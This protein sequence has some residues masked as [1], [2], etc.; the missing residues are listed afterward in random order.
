MQENE[1]CKMDIHEVGNLSKGV[2]HIFRVTIKC[3]EIKEEFSPRFSS[4]GAKPG[5]RVTS[6]QGQVCA[7]SWWARNSAC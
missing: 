5:D 1:I 2:K 3:P 7:E 6:P 4:P